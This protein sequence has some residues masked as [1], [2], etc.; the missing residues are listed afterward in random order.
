MYE[1]LVSYLTGFIHFKEVVYNH[2]KKL[3]DKKLV[4]LL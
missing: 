3:A 2:E 4:A 1:I